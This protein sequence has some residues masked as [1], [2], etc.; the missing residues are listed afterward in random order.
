MEKFKTVEKE[1]KTKAYSKEGLIAGAKLDPK[2][3]EKLD[4]SQFL[5]TMVEEIDRQVEALEA[6]E[7]TLQATMKKG[8]KD[9][10]KTD[11]L[12]DITDKLEKHKWHQTKLEL[13][14][15]ALENGKVEP[16]QVTDLQED[17]KYYV[18]ENGNVD[19]IDNEE[20]YDD[21]N[22]EEEEGQFGIGNDMDRISSQDTQS[23][24][25]DTDEPRPIGKAKGVEVTGTGAR[26]P[27]TQL[28]SPL[29]ALATL[30]SM[31]THTTTTT[32]TTMKPAPLPTR[33]PGETLKYAS[34]AA[35]GA[36]NDRNGVGIS[37]LPPPPGAASGLSPLPPAKTSNT[38][39]PSAAPSQP[40]T[41]ISSQKLPTRIPTPDELPAAQTQS[42]SPT[43][44]QSSAAIVSGPSSGPE[45]P[46]LDKVESVPQSSK[47]ASSSRDPPPPEPS[48]DRP[49]RTNGEVKEVED[50]DESIYH[51]PP[52]LQ[53]LIQSFEITKSRVSQ[54]MSTSV[55]RM[56]QASRD[57]CPEPSDSEKPRRY[58]PQTRYNTPSYYPQ[59]VLPIFDDPRLYETGRI[60]TDTLFY[61]FYYR[62]GTYQQY[63]A[64][65]SLK[66]QS[67]RFHK[68]YQ[69]WFQRHEEPKT[70]TDEFEQGTYRFFDYE[71]TWY[72]SP[73]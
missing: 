48:N 2:E 58:K 53:D 56:L 26:R 69:T 29:P 28:K 49:I 45:T 42:K 14:L 19:Y 44:S 1:M 31:A 64:A 55:Q 24:Q 40:A 17:I 16:M 20:M 6:E 46:A 33:Q 11:R 22:L 32:T 65:K 5:S 59:E 41:T 66:N 72:E 54:P 13:I 51:L 4:A 73:S 15:R 8:K 47:A 38:T 35:H 43:L 50:E 25:D 70:I 63:L 60:D 68:Q 39:S 71:S 21:L 18:N 23:I 9:V 3:K 30:H 12:S 57:S 67:W 62:Q 36:A 61:I 27:S 37:P 34:A 52:G 7:E 10:L